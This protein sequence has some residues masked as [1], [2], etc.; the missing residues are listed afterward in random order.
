MAKT[1]D[2]RK[3]KAELIEELQKLRRQVAG[4]QEQVDGSKEAEATLTQEQLLLHALMDYIPDFVYFKDTESH[5][6]RVNRSQSERFGLDDPTDVVGKTDFDFFTDEHA[7]P[8]YEDEQRIVRTGEPM[9]G[10]EEKETWPDGSVSWVS[11]SKLP[12]RDETGKTVGTFGVSRDITARKQAEV[13][14][15]RRAVQL[16]TVAEV[17]REAAAILDL[18]QLLDRMVNLVSDG[19]GFYHVGIFL[20]DEIGQYA[21]LRAASSEGGQRMLE[22]RY[23]LPVGQVGVVGSAVMTSE[24]H[25]ALDVGEDAVFFDNPDLPET[26][27]EMALPLW[28]RGEVIGVL[29]VQS[30]EPSAFTEEDVAI[31]LILADQLAIAIQNARLV[32]RTE[33]QLRELN[34]LYGQ[35]N[36]ETWERLLAAERPLGYVYDQID[37]S[38]VDE[39]PSPAYDLAVERN[40]IVGLDASGASE[41]V[42][43][44]PLRIRGQVIG[45]LGVEAD[46]GRDWTPEEVTLVEAVS[47]QVAQAIDSARLFAEAQK[48]ALSMESLYQTSRAISSSLEEEEMVRAVLEA[49]YRT[50]NCEHVLL[51]T[52]DE[53]RGTIGLQ[54][55]IWGGEFDVYPE[56]KEM[57]Q[58]SLDDQDIVPDIYRSGRTEIIEEWDGRFDRE[59][60]DKLGRERYLH[61]FMPIN[62]RERVIGV[63]EV[64][65]DKHQKDRISDDEVQMLSAFMDQAAVALE[66]V[67]LFDQ[68]QRRAQREHRT[69]EIANRLR[70]SPDIST[71][72]QT[73][74]DELGQTLRVDRA[75]VR[76]RVKP[77]EERA[78]TEESARAEGQEQP[79]EG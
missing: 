74:V 65:F 17:G 34:L 25:I 79:M 55:G 70:R 8:A 28:V 48:T 71:I 33:E 49:V 29:D 67:R 24:P 30:R 15:E 56:W 44:V 23:S 3:T 32:E 16:Q 39:L 68:V 51:S 2:M 37:V 36:A 10:L 77:R 27:S 50:L 12:L 9:L 58:Y 78:R 26:R 19:F 52:V 57:S 40:E 22:R 31:L 46:N 13:A 62:L 14:L 21:V 11:T 47:E 76:L 35:F 43:A 18:R 69:Y 59:I 6:I 45:S 5:F 60:W 1:S 66:N 64:A 72:L 63:V 41:S 73:A 53:E 75:I 20:L 7:R 4:P 42:L 54:H 61:I 38:P